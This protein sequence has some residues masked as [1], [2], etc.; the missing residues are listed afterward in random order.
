VR[1]VIANFRH[2][3]QNDTHFRDS[4]PGHEFVASLR[5]ADTE[6][7]ASRHQLTPIAPTATETTRKVSQSITMCTVNRF[8]AVIGAPQ[9]THRVRAF[10]NANFQ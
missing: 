2:S 9:T 5:R 6:S 3:H 1:V 10:L 7:A 8:S 4:P